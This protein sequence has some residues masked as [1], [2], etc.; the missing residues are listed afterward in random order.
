MSL[1]SIAF[2]AASSLLFS[3]AAFAGEVQSHISV[4]DAYARVSS[5]T[6]MSGAA[7]MLLT[8]HG[9]VDDVLISATS[10]AAKRTELHTHKEDAN[11][12]MKMVHVE[13]GFVVPAGGRHGLARGGDHVMLMGL[14]EPLEDGDQVTIILTFEHA[15][16]VTVDMLVDLNRKAAMKNHSKMDN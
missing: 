8:N 11:G 5:P 10:E 16:D 2:A 4:T 15:G 14:N 6:A 13:E 7:F 12:V 3:A 1:K 9:T